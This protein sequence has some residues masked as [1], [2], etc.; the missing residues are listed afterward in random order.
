MAMSDVMV[1]FH[2]GPHATPPPATSGPVFLGIKNISD[3]GHLDLTEVRHISEEDFPRWTKRATPQPDDVVFSY[4]ATLH[5]YALIPQG[6]RGCLGRRLALVRP[7]TS[8]V[9]PRFLHFAML[10]PAWR[11]TVQDRVISG[12]TVD[13]VPIIDFPKFPIELP[14]LDTQSRIVDVLGAIDDLIENNRRRIALLEQM[15]QAIYRQ[16]FVQFRYPGHEDDELVESP[17][18]SIPAGWEVLPVAGVAKIVRG[19]SYRGNELVDEGGVPFINLKCME[20]GGGFRRDGLKRYIGQFKPEQVTNPGDVVLAV[21][22]LTQGREILARATLVP[23]MSEVAGV[24][25][26]DVVRVVP[27]TADDRI[28]LFAVLRYSDLA[29][30]VKEFANGSTVLHLS[31]DHIAAANIVWPPPALRRKTDDVL[32][33]VYAMADDLADAADRLVGLRNLLLP[34]LVTGAINVSR[35]DFDD[36]A[37]VIIPRLDDPAVR[38]AL[39]PFV[40]Q[41]LAGF[42]N[43]RAKVDDMI[44]SGTL[45]VPVPAKRPS[46]SVLV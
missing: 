24:I 45:S 10:G 40:D 23:R 29:D 9:L 36:A 15:A 32:G 18:G 41:L 3:G 19:R 46:H 7:N 44:E 16:W 39:Q 31:P 6:F 4:E 21:T 22:D 28:P 33:P 42:T 35:L 26:L 38:A 8:V 1:E 20:R 43:V 30:R 37:E 25:S 14:D 27:N 2:D 34:R 5:R 11:S 17:L 13:R 12:S